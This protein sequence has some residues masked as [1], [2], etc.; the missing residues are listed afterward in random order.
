MK[1]F[2]DLNKIET[3]E[4]TYPLSCQCVVSLLLPNLF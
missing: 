2:K 1:N 4:T 3:L